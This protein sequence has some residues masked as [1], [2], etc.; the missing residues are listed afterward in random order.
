VAYERKG[1]TER[2]IEQYRKYLESAPPGTLKD[3]A[4]EA[5]EQLEGTI[6]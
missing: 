1:L 4:R 2:A 6:D 3:R 5:I